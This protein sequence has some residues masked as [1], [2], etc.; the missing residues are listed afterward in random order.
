MD[1]GNCLVLNRTRLLLRSG[2]PATLATD[3]RCRLAAALAGSADACRPARLEPH[4][5]DARLCLNT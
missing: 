1:G 3:R 2:R 5:M 4:E